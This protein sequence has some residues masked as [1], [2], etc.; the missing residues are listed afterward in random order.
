MTASFAADS[1][2]TADVHASPNHGERKAGKRADA[3]ILHYTGMKTGAAAL[4]L[5]CSAAS[6]VSCHYL[7]WEDGSIT[8]LV[9]EARRAWHAGRGVWAGDSDMNSRSIGIEIVNPGHPGGRGEA[10][11]PPYPR[12]QIRAVTALCADICARHAIAPQRVLAHSDIAPS[13]KIDPGERF[14]WASL[15]KAGVGHWVRPAPISETKGLRWGDSGN[16]VEHMQRLLAQYGYGATQTGS[17][18]AATEIAVRA[19]QRHF[20]P[21]RVDG[22]MDKSTFVTLRRLVAGLGKEK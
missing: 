19:F 5:L 16:Y 14:P 7:V 8:Q 22:M 10:P 6:E 1:P 17:Y 2:L 20:R 4:A 13:R 15:A 21:A 3:I 11:M 9:P 12:K 18:D